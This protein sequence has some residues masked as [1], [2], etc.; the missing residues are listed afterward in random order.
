MTVEELKNKRVGFIS[1]GCD[2]NRVD[3]ERI[4]FNFKCAGFQIVNDPSQA[5]IIVVNI[6][7]YLKKYA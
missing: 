4:I 1:L 5:N 2:K 7:K 6:C 3:L